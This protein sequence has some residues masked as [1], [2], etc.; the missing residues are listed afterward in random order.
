MSQIEALSGERLLVHHHG[1]EAITLGVAD[2]RF[3]RVATVR[4]DHDAAAELAAALTGM[5]LDLG[6]SPAGDPDRP[7]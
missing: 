1:H 7:V 5:L 2:P 6:R 3:G 4:L